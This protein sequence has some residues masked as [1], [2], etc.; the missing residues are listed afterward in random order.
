[1]VV[2]GHLV[3]LFLSQSGCQKLQLAAEKALGEKNRY[4]IEIK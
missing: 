1:L 3:R 4:V 2:Y